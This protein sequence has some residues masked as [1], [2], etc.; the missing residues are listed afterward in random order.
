MI[1][2]DNVQ[3][4]LLRIEDDKIE[5]IRISKGAHTKCRAPEI[6]CTIQLQKGLIIQWNAFNKCLNIILKIN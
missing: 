4:T 2:Q 6:K 5:L 1:I 3:L